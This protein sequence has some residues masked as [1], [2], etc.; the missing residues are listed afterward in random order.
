MLIGVKLTIDESVKSY[1]KKVRFL[2]KKMKMVTSVLKRDGD[3]CSNEIECWWQ[4]AS[5]RVGE[6]S[7]STKLKVEEKCSNNWKVDKCFK[8]KD[9]CYN[10]W[11]LI[12][13]ASIEGFQNKWHTFIDN[14]PVWFHKWSIWKAGCKKNLTPCYFQI[15]PRIST[16]EKSFLKKIQEI[17]WKK[18]KSKSYDENITEKKQVRV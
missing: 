5:T 11:M 15:D 9:K 10:K 18:C 13:S 4:S 17:I 3:K 16:Q 1:I 8:F 6:A 2:S 14:I 12:K 7:V